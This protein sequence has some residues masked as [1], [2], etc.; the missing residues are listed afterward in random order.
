MFPYSSP[1]YLALLVSRGHP[2]LLLVAFVISIPP[3][4]NFMITRLR[5]QLS[6]LEC[7]GHILK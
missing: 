1:S 5:L 7:Q 3:K 2:F 6:P 4:F